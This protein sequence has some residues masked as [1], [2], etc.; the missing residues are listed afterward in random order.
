MFCNNCGQPAEE[1]K[2]FCKTCGAPVGAVVAPTVAPTGATDAPTAPA[3]P[4]ASAPGPAPGY[5]PP[6]WPVPETRQTRGRG[7]LVAG[8][9]VAAV[10]V[11][12]GAGV[13]VY[14][15]FM[16]DGATSDDQVV[17]TTASTTM[18][19]STSTSAGTAST[20]GT[21]TTLAGGA[22]GTTI[23][24]SGSTVQTVP[25]LNTS[26]SKATTTTE[27]LLTAYLTATDELVADLEA[28]DARIPELATEINGT[29]PQVPQWVRDE[30]QAMADTLDV[31][32]A[33]L[34]ASE[35]PAG[36]EQSFQWLD[37]AANYMVSRINNTIAGIEVMWNTGKVSAANTY[38][39]Q[40]RV[41]RDAYRKAIAK[42]RELTPVD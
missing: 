13:G 33:K 8:I 31:R 41:D 9:V 5:G 21:T 1:G 39:N 4:V 24:S 23:P 11:L 18:A 26:T 36:F 25:S 12:A 40:G 27:E 3:P 7:P 42:Y 35:V 15:G 29:A 32:V 6:A 22:T 37:E 34:Y 10:L 14:F 20:A 16:R 2:P 17:V 38:F 19:Q 30:L 28:D